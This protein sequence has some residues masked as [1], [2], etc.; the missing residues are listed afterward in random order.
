MQ[1]INI[2]NTLIVLGLLIGVA[3]SSTSKHNIAPASKIYYEL[4]TAKSKLHWNCMH[5]G[6]LKFSKGS[7]VINENEEP[8]K[9]NF[10]INMA[11]I[12]N[13]DIENK[14]LQ[15]TLE[16]VLKSAEFFNAEK[17]PEAHFESDT[18]FK[19]NKS[20]N[21]KFRG[22]YIIFNNG[23][24]AVFE[25]TVKIENDTLYMHAKDII[26]NRTDWGIYYL[27]VNNPLPKDEES[28]F[29]VSDTIAIDAHIQAYKRL[30]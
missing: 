25:G 3:F 27:S 12:T 22:D 10:S 13:T 4:D 23:I 7:I 21:Y 16:N 19:S 20:N 29:T 28:G 26:L 30:K 6:E 24:C 2:K 15:G 1:L 17:Y 14:L 18:I 8:I 5:F 11:S 9:A